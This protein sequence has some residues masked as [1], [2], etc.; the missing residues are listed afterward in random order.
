VNPF[1]YTHNCTCNPAVASSGCTAWQCDVRELKKCPSKSKPC[2]AEVNFNGTVVTTTCCTTVCATSI[3]RLA[4]NKRAS[5][6]GQGLVLL[7]FRASFCD[8]DAV[9]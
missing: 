3:L 2:D 5:L 9:A 6:A 4:H 7:L 1:S 8:S